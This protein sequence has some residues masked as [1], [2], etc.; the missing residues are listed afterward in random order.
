MSVQSVQSVL[1]ISMSVVIAVCYAIAIPS[2]LLDSQSFYLSY[3]LKQDPPR[4]ISSFGLP[5]ASISAYLI[6]LARYLYAD[7]ITSEDSNQRLKWI[8]GLAGWSCIS[9]IGIGAVTINTLRWL[10]GFFAF[11]MFT[12]TTVALILMAVEDYRVV[13]R[14]CTLLVIWRLTSAVTAG[15][16][17]IAMFYGFTV[18]Y[19]V[20]SVSE[21][22]F[23]GCVMLSLT[24]YSK[25]FESYRIEL[26]LTR[27]S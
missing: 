7:G 6:F 8:N 10:H 27:V 19:L 22:V 2:D 9:L 4:A 26:S 17:L 1:V 5:I 25:E 16:S 13:Y 3:I 11:S 15:L 21:L 20:A 14:R 23:V 18:N 24:S 12:C